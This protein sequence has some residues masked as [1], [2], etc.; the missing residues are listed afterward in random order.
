[1]SAYTLMAVL[2]LVLGRLPAWLRGSGQRAA[3]GAVH[4]IRAVR[5][6]LGALAVFLGLAACQ[7]LPALVLLP[8]T[9]RW[10]LTLSDAG[11]WSL[12]WRYLS[13]AVLADHGGFHEWMTYTG[14]AGLV[15]ASAGLWSFC[16]KP[17]RR[18]GVG[19]APA[20]R[21]IL[22]WL[23]GLAIF[24]AWFS[25]GQNGG[26]FQILW[27]IVPGLGL[28]R[29]P[30]R[31]WVLVTFAT[32]V[33]AGFGVEAAIRLRAEGSARAGRWRRALLFG[34][35]ALPPTFALGYWLLYGELPL[36]LAML[37]VVAPLAIGL[38]FTRH[39][40]LGTE[41]LGVGAVLLVAADLVVADLTLIEGRP[42]EAVFSAGQEAA[43][44]MAARSARVRI[45]SPSFS[46]P[47]H[48]AEEHGLQLA[49]GVDPLQLRAY[50][51]FLTQAAS[52]R[53]RQGYSVTLPPLPEGS[54][55]QTALRDIC[56]DPYLLGRLGVRYTV[57]AFPLACSGQSAG[58]S[59]QLEGRFGDAYIYR[60][61]E[62]RPLTTTDAPMSVALAD[63]SELFRYKPWPVYAGW[64]VSSATLIGL[65]L[66]T[67]IR[68]RS[69]GV[70]G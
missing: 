9:T 68:G 69:G 48:V 27:R 46:I 6:V 58:L 36:N 67:L 35:S 50:A 10:S 56:P 62:A 45:Y 63:G 30:P 15:F 66:W 1:M 20:R 42:P 17:E 29:V 3:A 11:V 2:A 8:D 49:G 59:W 65:A 53:P 39:P 57:A 55:V 34:A 37:G 51:D 19:Q 64:A 54:D 43:D 47:Q 52:L 70:D 23:V 44:W 18:A 38:C 16:R 7:W 61:Q 14:V 28:L 33:L 32:A 26:L 40:R 22:G 25:L 24:G 60:N 5:V 4:R 21:W 41:F 13:G 31:A 12:P